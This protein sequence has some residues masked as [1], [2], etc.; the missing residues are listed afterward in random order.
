MM[1]ITDPA[2]PSGVHSQHLQPQQAHP[3][4]RESKQ[5]GGLK[6]SHVTPLCIANQL[7]VKQP[8]TTRLW[9]SNSNKYIIINEQAA[10]IST[11]H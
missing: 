9:H 3:K 10:Q 5:N 8:N 4:H 11:E 2:S 1:G 7:I 6:Q